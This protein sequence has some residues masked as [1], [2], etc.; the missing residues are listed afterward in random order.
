MTKSVSN[1]EIEKVSKNLNK[2]TINKNFVVTFPFDR[3]NK[4][5]EFHKFMKEKKAKY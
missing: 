3:I 1:L 5:F 4:F 2:E